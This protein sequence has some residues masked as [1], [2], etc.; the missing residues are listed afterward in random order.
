MD[1]VLLIVSLTLALSVVALLWRVR[2]LQNH[3]QHL[4]VR[5][6][7][8]QALVDSIPDLTWVKDLDSRFL[9]VNR[10]FTKAFGL[11]SEEILG[12]T[13]FDLSESEQAKK[14]LEDDLLVINTRQAIHREERITGEGGAESWA[15]T[16]KVPIIGPDGNVEG[17]AGMARDIS[18]R[19]RAERHINHLAH[20]DTLTNLPNR[21]LLERRV[22]RYL[23]NHD[24]DTDHL[25]VMFIDLDN[26]KVIN[27]TINHHVGDNI[28]IELAN[29]LRSLVRKDD[30]VARIGGDEFVVVLPYTDVDEASAI[31]EKLRKE[32]LL[33][34]HYEAISFE[35]TF[36]LGIAIYPEDGTDCWGLVQN[37]D[38]AM[39][40]SKQA[41]KNRI[42]VFSRQ[43]ADR[44]IRRMTLDSRMKEALLKEE[45]SLRY[46]PKVDIESGRLIG[47]EALLRWFDS[48]AN[49]FVSP[50]EFI[51]AAEQS[52]FILTLGEWVIDT[53]TK[54][55]QRWNEKGFVTKVAINVSAIQV[56]Q[57]TLVQTI[58][59][60]LKQFGV[61]GSQIEL[62]L[63]ESIIMENSDRIIDNL[64]KI[65]DQGVTISIDDFGTGYSNLA[66]LS[67]F[68]VSTLKIDR[69]FVEKIDQRQDGRRIAQ[70]IVEMARSL[71]L[72]VIA[73]GVETGEEL[74]VMRE[75]GVQHVQGY[76]FDKPL[77]AAEIEDRLKESWH[78]SL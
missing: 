39:Y 28:L 21:T 44:S 16:V 27:D 50:L 41:G 14:Y 1:W 20:H 32:L 36:S 18:E 59:D 6:S 13:D 8:F 43:L 77:M 29:R 53:V 75:I 24:E 51:P 76:L 30:T 22:K 23:Q 15:E 17:T 40:H 55:L 9:M 57:N 65:L 46:Q 35:I 60:K 48:S 26:F 78:Y 2:Q 71:G 47:F 52:G 31:A 10:Q 42:T 4:K 45:F 37:A 62:E 5:R 73:E 63:T 34:I 3:L 54:Q 12:K 11:T 67:R 72:E 66:Y 64:Q 19:K 58:K 7:H 25:A 69:A 74:C 33:P 70:A 61:S 38:L 56:H 49:A 68:P